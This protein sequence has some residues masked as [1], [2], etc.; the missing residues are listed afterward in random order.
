MNRVFMLRRLTALHRSFSYQSAHHN[1]RL[2]ITLAATRKAAM[3]AS[4][5]SEFKVSL[6]SPLRVLFNSTTRNPVAFSLK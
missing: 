4:A 3:S 2:P 5:T 6:M 1:L